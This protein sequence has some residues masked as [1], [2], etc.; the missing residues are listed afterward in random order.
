VKAIVKD[1]AI[2]H[3]TPA[4]S[5]V[6]AEE[7]S[8]STLPVDGGEISGYDGDEIRVEDPK[9]RKQGQLALWLIGLLT[10]AI[11]GH[12]L[13]I[14]ILV[15]KGKEKPEALTAAFN[16]ALPVISGLVAS[17]VTFYFTKH[18]D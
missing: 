12:Y 8:A 18:N 15:F 3:P 7:K 10:V 13:A 5:P 2:V 9:I 4:L 6:D 14:F 11:V 16:V 1:L 17:A